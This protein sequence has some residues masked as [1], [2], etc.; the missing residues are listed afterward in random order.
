[1]AGSPTVGHAQLFA[2]GKLTTSH[3]EVEGIRFCIKCHQLGK[4]GVSNVRCLDCHDPLRA[5]VDQERGFHATVTDQTCGECHKEHFGRDFDPINLDSTQFDHDATG[6][7]LERGHVEVACR[8]CHR[9]EF[10][11]SEDVRVFKT[12]YDALE[13]TFLGLGT[14]CELCHRTDDPHEEQFPDQRCEDCHAATA[15]DDTRRFDHDGTRYRLTGLHRDV[16]CEDC[17]KPMGGPN[18][19]I[20]FVDMQFEICTDCHEDVHEG[21]RRDACTECHTTE[22][23][24]EFERSSFERRFDHEQTEFSLVGKHA[25][26]ECATCHDVTRARS[27]ELWITFTAETWD[28]MYPIPVVTD[29]TSCHVDYHDGVFEDSP[30][31]IVCESCHTGEGWLPSTYDIARHNT[32]SEY[33]LT[34]AHVAVP[35]SD[36]HT[37]PLRPD[38][39]KFHFVQSDCVS[40]HE[41]DL[42][43][44]TQFP[45]EECTTCH[46]ARAWAIESYDHSTGNFPLDGAHQSVP[47]NSCHPLDADAV[48]VSR[49]IYKPL[50]TDCRDCHGGTP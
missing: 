31:G 32:D 40:C 13:R 39:L 10:I 29:C 48:D 49:R 47:C 46:D 6:Y 17:H 20:Q 28:H 11:T 14:T 45:D 2:P 34:G 30:G 3:E 22:G 12:R 35:C 19:P 37:D 38:S 26:N 23:W 8:D 5:R 16:P 4:V 18:G 1:M 24:R 44:G 33:E 7:E 42:P 21:S 27:D 25:E 50:G 36:C 41:D 9:P 15:W 43:H